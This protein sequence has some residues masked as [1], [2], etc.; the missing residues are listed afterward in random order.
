[1]V[2]SCVARI[3]ESTQQTAH[4]QATTIKMTVTNYTKYITQT[5]LILF[6]LWK[7]LGFLFFLQTEL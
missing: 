5:N 7:L 3:Q 4:G 2:Y 1:M 6:T